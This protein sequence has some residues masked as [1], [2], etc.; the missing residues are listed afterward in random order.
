MPRFMAT[1]SFVL[2]DEQLKEMAAK[3]L[4]DGVAWVRTF[5]GRAGKKAFCEWEAPSKEA[6]EQIL[7]QVDVPYDQVYAVRLFDVATATFEP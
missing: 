3:P 5:S 4:P 1:H 7:K 6:V 2:S